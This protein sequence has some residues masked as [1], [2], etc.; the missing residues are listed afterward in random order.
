MRPH[1]KKETVDNKIYF[2]TKQQK[3]Q[4][5]KILKYLLNGKLRVRNM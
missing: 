5:I 1:F 2:K 4:L 3:S